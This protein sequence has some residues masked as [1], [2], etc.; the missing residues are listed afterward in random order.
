M[1]TTVCMFLKC[2]STHPTQPHV[3]A[4]LLEL[5]GLQQLLHGLETNKTLGKQ[6]NKNNS[7]LFQGPRPQ[8]DHMTRLPRGGKAWHR[9]KNPHSSWTTAN[10]DRVAH[11]PLDRLKE[12][13]STI[14]DQLTH[15]LGLF[16]SKDS[17]VLSI[18]PSED[19]LHTAKGW[20][21]DSLSAGHVW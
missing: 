3:V 16:A 9:N 8:R 14:P 10:T 1:E 15:S 21:W 4:A 20:Q 11:L 6:V 7:S 2:D 19:R 13:K 17:S 18:Q 5:Q 12:A